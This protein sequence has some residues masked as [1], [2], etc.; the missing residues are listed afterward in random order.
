MGG[1]IAW[2]CRG[3][4]VD[5]QWICALSARED[6]PGARSIYCNGLAEQAKCQSLW[7]I[8]GISAALG[9]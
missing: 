4:G 6:D 1:G 8:A 2:E 7:A 5:A 3:S 9:M